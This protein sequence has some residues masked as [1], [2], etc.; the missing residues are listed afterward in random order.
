MGNGGA[1]GFATNV[2]ILGFV[3][4]FWVNCFVYFEVMVVLDLYCLV[5]GAVNEKFIG[6]CYVKATVVAEKLLLFLKDT[7]LK[8]LSKTINAIVAI[9]K[10]L[11]EIGSLRQIEDKVDSG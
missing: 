6:C 9:K 3:K 1:V 11:K 10:M 5:S 4:T 2:R 7:V 8:S